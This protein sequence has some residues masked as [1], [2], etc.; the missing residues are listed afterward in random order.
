MNIQTSVSIILTIL[1]LSL[2]GAGCL[3]DAE[4]V[5]SKSAQGEGMGDLKI[6]WRTTWQRVP[7]QNQHLFTLGLINKEQVPLT[8]CQITL[9]DTINQTKDLMFR[10]FSS[11]KV[12]VFS[13]KVQKIEPEVIYEIGDDIRSSSFTSGTNIPDL[14][15]PVQK[16]KLECGGKSSE[17]QINYK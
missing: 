3:P 14:S 2:L 10:V 16:V 8:D 5:A 15:K 7:V 1:P 17:W 13:E 12:K 11:G 6:E 9:N 4:T